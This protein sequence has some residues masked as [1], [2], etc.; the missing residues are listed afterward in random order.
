MKFY[1]GKGGLLNSTINNLLF[2]LHITR[3]YNYCGSGTKVEK[4]L[5]RNDS[6]INQVDEAF[7]EHDIFYSK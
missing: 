2:E 1:S 3:G 4:H 6:G 5:A 7:K